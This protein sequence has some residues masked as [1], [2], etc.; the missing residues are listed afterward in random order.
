[1]DRHNGDNISH[2]RKNPL[3]SFVI[4]AMLGYI[5]P[6]L[7][8]LLLPLYLLVLSP[9][10]YGVL[11]LVNVG[12]AV[13][14][15]FCTWNMDV[16]MR[17]FYFDFDQDEKLLSKYLTQL[18]SFTLFLSV[19]T[20][21]LMLFLGPT[22]YNI[23][24]SS[25]S[26]SYVP[27][28]SIAL[29]TACLS[30]C[31]NIYLV[32]LKNKIWLWEF[33][34]YSLLS[35]LLGIGFQCYLLLIC[36]M[37]VLGVLLG[38]FLSTL[39]VFTTIVIRR[40]LLV[41]FKLVPKY[42]R[43]SIKFVLPLI[44]MLVLFAI[45][46]QIDRV[47]LE[48]YLSLEVVGIYALLMALL[49][50][51]NV[52]FSA[53]DDAIRP[54]LYESLKSDETPQIVQL[55]QN[56]YLLVGT[57]TFLLVIAVGANL[58]LITDNLAYISV[59]KYIIYGA[60]ACLPLIFVRY[61]ALIYVFYKKSGSL[62]AITLIKTIAVIGLLIILVPQ[63]EILGALLAVLLSNVVAQCIFWTQL[64]K[65]TRVHLDLKGQILKLLPFVLIT[66]LVSIYSTD[67]WLSIL[68]LIQI[69]ALGILYLYMY[70]KEVLQ[71]I[72]IIR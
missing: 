3:G 41:T 70:K 59:K 33:A 55:F 43:P 39:I 29:A 36:H 25:D 65:F 9:S 52:M 38:G 40:P 47:F 45:E 72:K 27:L 64:K 17:T 48:K 7:S 10:E 30:T 42:I 18:F 4:F 13:L 69:P 66:I 57:L 6:A 28:G 24:F 50:L 26:I 61:Y 32:F 21:S 44:P 34:I 23:S 11:A 2:R 16:A 20:Y 54:F 37:G 1:M 62:T 22:M 35:I 58:H 31:A 53:L 71:I 19:T 67:K 60:I 49:G 8:I 56:M 12:T 63:Y 15:I 68:C 5:R 46:K 14:V 51:V